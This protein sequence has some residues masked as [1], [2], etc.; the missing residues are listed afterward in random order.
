MTETP[1]RQIHHTPVSGHTSSSLGFSPQYVDTFFG[2]SP[3]KLTPV[4]THS[5]VDSAYLAHLP[6]SSHGRPYIE[7][8]MLTGLG[9]TISAQITKTTSPR[10]R[11]H[12]NRISVELEREPRSIVSCQMTS[13]LLLETTMKP[14]PDRL[15]P[16]ILDFAFRSRP[17][18]SS[19]TPN[20]DPTLLEIPLILPPRTES[21]DVIF[22]D[23]PIHPLVPQVPPVL[24]PDFGTGRIAANDQ[25]CNIPCLR[26]KAYQ[27]IGTQIHDLPEPM[28]IDSVPELVSIPHAVPPPVLIYPTYSF[29]LAVEDLSHPLAPDQN[30]FRFLHETLQTAF[31][32]WDRRVTN[33]DAPYNLDNRILEVPDVRMNVVYGRRPDQSGYWRGSFQ[34]LPGQQQVV[35]LKVG[36]SEDRIYG[37]EIGFVEDFKVGGAWLWYGIDGKLYFIPQQSCD[38]GVAEG[39]WRTYWVMS[40]GH[41]FCDLGAD[42]VLDPMMYLNPGFTRENYR[43]NS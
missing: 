36:F 14:M 30:P 39:E 12:T 24:Q 18:P 42:K 20:S 21:L 9:R 40:G 41:V 3:M 13:N 15:S 10:A 2:G 25:A 37:T 1:V 35:K 17:V 26:P 27:Y 8:L 19:P 29:P 6:E 22:A 5:V 34:L 7:E 4:R 31:T 28:Q 33:K 23:R 43:Q 32:D 11:E 16:K 38:W